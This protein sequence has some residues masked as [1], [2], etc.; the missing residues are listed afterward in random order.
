MAR[1]PFSSG[2]AAGERSQAVVDPP[3]NPLVPVIVAGPVANPGA[4]AILPDYTDAGVPDITVH[5]PAGA[6]SGYNVTY[7][8]GSGSYSTAAFFPFTLTMSSPSQ[9]FDLFANDSGAVQSALD[10]ES[11][12]SLFA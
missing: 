12:N 3:I 11:W 6:S 1:R 4:Q 8:I 7:R 9:T 10:T 2:L 5:K